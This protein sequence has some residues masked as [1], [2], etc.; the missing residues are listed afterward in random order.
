MDRKRIVDHSLMPCLL[1]CSTRISLDIGVSSSRNT[2]Y[3]LQAHKVKPISPEAVVKSIA[4][5]LR[6]GIGVMGR[7][8]APGL[9]PPRGDVA[10]TPSPRGQ[11][12][13]QL[14]LFFLP[15][16][17]VPIIPRISLDDLDQKFLRVISIAVIKNKD[18][19]QD[20]RLNTAKNK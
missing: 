2:L 7:R 20:L 13:G 1:R 12:K 3:T 10:Q 17:L 11:G 16:I 4:P 6:R 14:V 18:L 8:P 5:S 19:K 9:N 15:V